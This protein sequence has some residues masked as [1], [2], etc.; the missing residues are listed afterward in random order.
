MRVEQRGD[1]IARRGA[2]AVQV[3]DAFDL[4]ERQPKR[5]GPDDEPQYFDVVIG[6]KSVA[7]FGSSCRRQQSLGFPDSDGFCGNANRLGSSANGMGH[8]GSLLTR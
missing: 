5:F 7:G 4:R 3:E 8:N 2:L 1:L 6:E